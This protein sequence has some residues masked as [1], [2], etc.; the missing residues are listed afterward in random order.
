[1]ILSVDEKENAVARIEIEITI[2]N[3]SKAAIKYL[4]V[5][6]DLSMDAAEPAGSKNSPFD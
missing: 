3:I 5:R 6:T 2:A 4:D 1:M